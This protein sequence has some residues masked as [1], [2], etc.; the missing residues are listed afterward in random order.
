VANSKPNN[1][2][3]KPPIWN[4]KNL[5]EKKFQK[6]FYFFFQHFNFRTKKTKRFKK[7]SEKD[8]FYNGR[9]ALIEE[10]HQ[11]KLEM[12]QE[13]SNQKFLEYA[14][15]QH[16]GHE[17]PNENYNNNYNNNLINDFSNQN[18]SSNRSTQRNS[19]S[20]LT[21]NN[22]NGYDTN[23]KTNNTI[24]EDNKNVKKPTESVL[25]LLTKNL[26]ANTIYEEDE[27]RY[28]SHHD[29]YLQNKNL[30]NG[31]NNN[32]NRLLTNRSNSSR[33]DIEYKNGFVPFMRTNEFLDPVHAT[34][35]IPPSRET[36]AIKRDREKARQVMPLIIFF[37]FKKASFI[38]LLI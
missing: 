5:E 28:S 8:P 15:Q 13:I 18:N 2:N 19:L 16:N 22:N 12:K 35:P 24:S 6:F 37:R 33:D 9:R 23:R 1:K 36:S 4:Y 7:N 25:N 14:Q 21:L 38:F 30:F 31:G 27:D 34:S 32:N 3:N 29:P 20:T 11:K 10:R 17:S 26:A